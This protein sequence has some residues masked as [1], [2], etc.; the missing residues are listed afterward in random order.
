MNSETVAAVCQ[1]APPQL[2]CDLETGASGFV[3]EMIA[4][5]TTDTANR[6]QHLRRAAAD[7]DLSGVRAEVHAIR[8][9]AREMGADALV[10]LCL[11]I[12]RKAHDPAEPNIS[13][14]VRE[15]EACFGEVSRAMARYCTE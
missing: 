3:A 5:F 13:D 11:E 12:E 9:S 1:W 10:R 6:L 4:D 8:G 15:L 7:A 2:L 14:C